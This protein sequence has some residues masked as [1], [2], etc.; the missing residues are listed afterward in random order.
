VPKGQQSATCDSLH[1]HLDNMLASASL[2]GLTR[3]CLQLL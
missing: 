2:L 1:R 3:K